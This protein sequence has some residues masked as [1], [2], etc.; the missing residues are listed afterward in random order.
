[1]SDVPAIDLVALEPFMDDAAFLGVLID[2][3][4][5]EAPRRMSALRTAYAAG[6]TSVLRSEGHALKGSAR[7]FGAA[8]MAAM[9][10]ALETTHVVDDATGDWLGQLEGEFERVRAALEKTR[11]EAMER[12]AGAPSSKETR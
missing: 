11:A 6:D 1:M 8:P 5:A 2:E 12:G 10:Q 4:F 3:F 9:C 7:V